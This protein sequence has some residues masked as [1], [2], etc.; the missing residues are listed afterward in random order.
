[1]IEVQ[2][3]G[4]TGDRLPCMIDQSPSGLQLHAARSIGELHVRSSCVVQEGIQTLAHYPVPVHHQ[5]AYAEFKTVHLPVTESSAQEIVSMPIYPELEDREVEMVIRAVLLPGGPAR[6]FQ[7][8][9]KS[10]G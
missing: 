6:G 9:G 3:A 7:G 5:A 10:I 2:F 8:Y 4:G 1:M